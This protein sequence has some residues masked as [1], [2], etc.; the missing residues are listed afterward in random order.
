MGCLI[1]HYFNSPL[2]PRINLLFR[3]KHRVFSMFVKHENLQSKSNFYFR[4]V[5]LP[6][7]NLLI[8]EASEDKGTFLLILGNL[9]EVALYLCKPA[10]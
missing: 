1:N 6:I 10:C 2:I 7:G 8:Y 3:I 4:Y 9:E 5:C